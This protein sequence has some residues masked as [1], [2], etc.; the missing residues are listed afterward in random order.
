MAADHFI[1]SRELSASNTFI[2]IRVALWHSCLGV[3]LI[4]GEQQS[5]ARE[6][7]P[8]LGLGVVPTGAVTRKIITITAANE[9]VTQP[10]HLVLVR[11]N[12]VC[13]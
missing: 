3:A 12:N 4:T 11:V 6:A 1:R 13:M 7:I 5:T 8:A 9:V 2:N 10:T